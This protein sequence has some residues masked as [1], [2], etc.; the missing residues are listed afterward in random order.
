MPR[1]KLL[2]EEVINKIAAGEVVDR[3]ASVVRELIENSLDA[4]AARIEV[5]VRGGGTREIRVIDDGCGMER[6]DLL[7]AFD[8]HS[9]SKLEKFSDLERIASMGFRGEALPSIAGVSEVR[10]TTR[11]A[12]ALSATRIEIRGGAIREVTE[13]GAPAGTEVEVKRLFFNTPARRKFLKTLRTETARITEEVIS[14]G[15]ANP[16]VAFSFQLDGEKVF[17]LPAVAGIRERIADLWGGEAAGKLVPVRGTEAGARLAGWVVDPDA[18]GLVRKGLT[19]VVNHRPIRDRMLAGAVREGYGHRLAGGGVPA[20]V[21]AIEVGAGEVDVNIHPAKREVRFSR[22]DLIRRL[23]VRAVAEGLTRRGGEPFYRPAARSTPG[24]VMETAG[25]LSLPQDELELFPAGRS[26]AAPEG[27][28]TV[29]A[30]RSLHA[31]IGQAGNRYL[32]VESPRGVSL[33]DQHA[34]HERVLYERFR[35]A[36]SSARIEVQPLLTPVNLDL[37]PSRAARLE[38]A[39]TGLG[40]LGIEIEPFGND[41]FIIRALP[42]ILFDWNREE[43]V[44]ELISRLE[45]G[46]RPADPREEIII[47]LAC[48]AAVKARQRLGTVELGRLVEELLACREPDRCPHG[49]PTMITLGWE[50]LEKRFGRR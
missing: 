22:P 7:L 4:G 38:E 34:A 19:L 40:E 17:T 13:A 26:P 48:L 14:H 2:P 27:E 41:S 42:A 45:E 36:L 49:R 46:R 1:I 47:R 35:E 11:P 16:A 10:V 32:L 8:R 21:I 30:G 15:L 9:T 29:P 50:E 31:L 23:T 43:L 3:P 20:G 33:I 44:L 25:T 37:T 6:D 12:E 39:I 24:G 28:E 18:A 5:A